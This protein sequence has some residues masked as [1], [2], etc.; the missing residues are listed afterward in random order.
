MGLGSSGSSGAVLITHKRMEMTEGG[1]LCGRLRGACQVGCAHCR[2]HCCPSPANFGSQGHA[3]VLQ[4]CVLLSRHWC[5]CCCGC[6][7]A[8]IHSRQ[9]QTCHNTAQCLNMHQFKRNHDC[10][11]ERHTAAT[12]PVSG[13][14]YHSKN[15]SPGNPVR[16]T[17]QVPP[18]FVAKDG[19]SVSCN[20]VP[21]LRQS[22]S[23][24]PRN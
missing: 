14:Q 19:V 1:R 11:I 2:G 5:S 23:L 3:G 7:S 9:Q 20:R 6:L 17:W 21:Y 24:E 8:Q 18:Y 22:M 15:M 16:D 12:A 13:Q 10:G 4:A